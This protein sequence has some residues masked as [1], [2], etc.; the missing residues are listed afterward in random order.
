MIRFLFLM[1]FIGLTHISY[2]AEP[3]IIHIG[4]ASNFSEVAANSY[5]PF[6]NSVRNGVQLALKKI[7][8]RFQSKGIRVET[9]EFNY[10]GNLLKVKDVVNQAAASRVLAVVGYE[11]SDEAL[12]AAPLHHQLQFAMLTP[13]ASADRLGTF[14][15]FVHQGSFNNSYQGEVLARFAV[16]KLHC[17]KAALIVVADCAYC[18]DLATAFIKKYQA[19]GGKIVKNISVLSEDK[20]LEHTLFQLDPNVIDT[21]I[22]PNHE[23]T[24]ARIITTLLKRG[25]FKPYLG[26]D[27]WR[28]LGKDFFKQ[29]F[30][31]EF[32]GYMVAH[33]HL[34]STKPQSQEF[35]REY[36]KNF[37]TLPTDSAAL[38]YDGMMLMGDAL[39][40]MNRYDRPSVEQALNNITSFDG[41]TGPFIFSEPNKAPKKA[42]IIMK[43]SG[44]GFVADQVLEP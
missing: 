23:L 30:S 35:V 44:K 11:F 28:T 25:I 13:S 2:A 4:I 33:W 38:A 7:N 34:N 26:G 27:G 40:K 17:K 39:S 43:S 1:V 24:S 42:V 18:V 29:D 12:I 32:Q 15:S 16:D 14:G 37:G 31:K 10:A 21:I 6:G 19:A 41:V 36:Q 3:Q 5:N 9:Q 8:A 22:V 20:D